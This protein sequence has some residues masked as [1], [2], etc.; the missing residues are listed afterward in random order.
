MDRSRP[1]SWAKF[2][3]KKPRVLLLTS[4][5]FLM[6]EVVAACKRLEI[7]HLFLDLQTKEMGIEDFVNSV[8]GAITSFLPDMVLTV[9]HLGVDR[10]GV[11]L[12][13]LE[14][15]DIPLASWFV[16]NPFLI[17]PV[18][19]LK[20]TDKTVI[21]SWDADNLEPLRELGYKH[22]AY[23]PLAAD[24]HRFKAS[25]KGYKKQWESD[26]SF[27]GNSM[28]TKVQKRLRAAK[29][30]SSLASKYKEIAA[31]F[32]P[33]EAKSAA[34][35]LAQNFPQ[36]LNDFKALKTPTRM[37]AFETLLTWQSTLDYRLKC[38][39]Q[40]MEFSPLIVGDKGWGKLLAE[41]SGQ[42]RYHQEVNY[43]EDLPNLYP[44]S[45]VNFNATSLQMKGAVNQRVFDVPAAGAFLITDHRRQMEELFEPGKEI[46]AYRDPEEI[47]ELVA[48]YLKDA[49]AR[50]KITQAAQK[51]IQAQH[52]Y[53]RRIQTLLEK[54]R[55][56][57]G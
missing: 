27:V 9:N 24:T 28:L 8:L 44:L 1:R 54:M 46:V 30:N 39:K 7:P 41:F 16:D 10:E 19:P 51:R 56:Q 43:Y 14:Q 49:N 40:I 37:L 35:F 3:N 45:K 55:F 13:I 36:C 57:F 6:G 38:V 34:R 15:M 5:F 53:D 11:L 2:Q 23:L 29:P 20:Y 18:Y 4:Q 17:L 12:Q 50:K 33:S 21:F 22:V 52:T 25:E 26:V 47:P 31:A 42:W 48:K 32:G